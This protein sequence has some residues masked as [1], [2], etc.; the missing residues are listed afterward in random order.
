M[1]KYRELCLEAC[2]DTLHVVLHELEEYL[3][4]VSCSNDCKM[5]LLIATEEIFINIAH[6]AYG[7]EI[8]K[9]YI[10]IEIKDNPKSI[11]I[12]FKDQGTPYNPLEKEDPDITLSAEERAIGG[13]GIYMVKQSMDHVEYDYQDGYNILRIEKFF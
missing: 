6:Y 4:T 2:D 1:T 9:A 3:N 12:T 13:L 11:C 5:E 7:G 10:K 8:G